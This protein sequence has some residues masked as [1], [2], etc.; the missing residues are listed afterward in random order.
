MESLRDKRFDDIDLAVPVLLEDIAPDRLLDLLLDVAEAKFPL[1]DAL[2]RGSARQA[3]YRQHVRA[4]GL[5]REFLGERLSTNIDERVLD[6]FVGH[7]VSADGDKRPSYWREFQSCVRCLVN[8][9]PD[10]MRRRPLLAPLQARWASKL[11]GLHE[12][13]RL[14]LRGFLQRGMMTR[15]GPDGTVVL[16]PH[17]LSDSVR[18]NASSS[19]RTILKALGLRDLRLLTC[20]KAKEFLDAYTADGRRNHALNHIHKA[21]PIF[22]YLRAKQVVAEDPFMGIAEMPTKRKNKDYVPQDG[23]DRLGDLT[24][25]DMESVRE[26]RDR[27]IAFALLYDFALRRGECARLDLGDLHVERAD[28]G[29]G[30]VIR[31]HVRREIQKGQNKE[32]VDLYSYF[33]QTVRLLTRYLELRPRL[34]PKT[35]ALIVAD[36]GDRL[37]DAGIADAVARQCGMLKIR[38]AAGKAVTCHRLRHSAGSLNVEPLGLSL[39]IYE[40][41]RRLRHEDYQVTKQVYLDE[42]PLI[43]RERHMVTL[44]R[45]QNGR[46]VEPTVSMRHPTVDDGVPEPEAI[47]RLSALGITAA[48]LEREGAKAGA[49]IKSGHGIAYATAFVGDLESNYV[50]KAEAMR[51]LNFTDHQ[52]WHWLNL[53]GSKARLVGKAS[54]VRKNDIW[55]ELR[56]RAEGRGRPEKSGR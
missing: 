28:Q 23:I 53:R 44:R 37:G 47:R 19:L 1:G 34:E 7:L 10:D 21:W 42:N 27:S 45:I 22:R 13:T 6:E 12:E 51:V 8:G 17:A 26:V 38:T 30:N 36:D 49:L 56:A 25:L 9:L 18:E 55:D 43:Q 16:R 52:L 4:I 31:L 2:T 14:I 32:A 33:P 29:L 39:T 40:I 50:A 41:M 11:S 15:T 46:G 5:F 24:R 54:L 20:D 48:A 3:Q 35:D